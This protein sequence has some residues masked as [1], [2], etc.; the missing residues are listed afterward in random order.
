VTNDAAVGDDS[1]AKLARREGRGNIPRMQ[2]FRSVRSRRPPAGAV[3]LIASVVLVGAI[4]RAQT[5]ARAAEGL[6]TA[7]ETPVRAAPFDVAPELTRVHAG[8]RLPADDQAQGAWR[9]VRL[10][11]GRYGFLPDAA[12]TIT[13]VG[14]RG[15]SPVVSEPRTLAPEPRPGG[16]NL[17][18]VMFEILPVGTLKSTASTATST[19]ASADSVF[20][21]A[22]APTL[23]IS[24]SPTFAIG[25]SPQIIFRVKRDASTSE[26]ATEFDFRGRLTVRRPMSP[27]VRVYGRLSPAFSIISLPAGPSNAQASPDPKGFLVDF[28]V[29]TE[30]ALLPNLFFVVDLGYQL[31]FQSSTSA[32]GSTT[33]NGSRY[34]HLGGG[35]AIVL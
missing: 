12:A 31:G 13:G 15:P 26:S 14:P 8:D 18:G 27:T 25:A 2:V 30:V 22:V 17:F 29:G 10:P 20:A 33:F 28:S 21:V 11:D 4:I 6:V 7:P 35:L 24:V 16:P 3:A 23:D 34:L 9:R 5:Q 19:N 32:D 1:A